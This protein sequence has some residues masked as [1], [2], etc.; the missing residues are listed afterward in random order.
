MRPPSPAAAAVA[1]TFRAAGRFRAS[2]RGRRQQ[3]LFAVIAACVAA[4]GM[5]SPVFGRIVPAT[6][7]TAT[8]QGLTLETAAAATAEAAAVDRLIADLVAEAAYADRE[9]AQVELVERGMAIEPF[10][11][12]A[13]ATTR[14]EEQRSR[15]ELILKRVAQDAV[16]GPTR[17]TLAAGSHPAGD[18][19]DAIA[20]QGGLRVQLVPVD[21]WQP[22]AAPPVTLDAERQPLWAVLR[23][24]CQQLA[25]EPTIT[26]EGVRLTPST[27][28]GLTRGPAAVAGPLLVAA[29]RISHQRAIDLSQG[30]FR[31]DEFSIHFNVLAEPKLR[32]MPGPTAVE[33]TVADDDAGNSL[34]LR[35]DAPEVNYNAGGPVWAFATRLRYPDQPGQRIARLA[36]TIALPVATQFATVQVTDLPAAMENKTDRA[37]ANALAV[38]EANTLRFVV[39]GVRQMGE[40]WEVSLSASAPRGRNEEFN[41][42]QQLLYNPDVRLLDAAGRSIV[43]SAGPNFTSSDQ[44]NT[45]ELTLIF[46]RNLSDGRPTPGPAR[47]L[48]WRIPTETRQLTLPFELTDLPMP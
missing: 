33:I 23:Q 24:V 32:V 35:R 28:C 21:L 11:L 31:T 15:L 4:F 2:L 38:V 34:L 40:R 8:A 45:L 41:R 16:I 14:D 19:I 22:D 44:P 13:L 26:D 37:T 10:A 5:A 17:I 1:A 25:L 30:G 20:R 46:D 39:R 12:R 36:G 7:P 6:Q 42:V 43:R 3:K 47:S 27:G 29:S 18:V 9:L 48:V